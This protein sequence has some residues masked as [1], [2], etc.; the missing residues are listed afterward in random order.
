MIYAM[1]CGLK[2]KERKKE[3]TEEPEENLSVWKSGT[4]RRV[5]FLFLRERVKGEEMSKERGN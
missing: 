1:P 5:Y 3:I 2:G 4:F